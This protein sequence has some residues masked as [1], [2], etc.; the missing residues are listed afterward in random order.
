MEMR[1]CTDTQTVVG[2]IENIGSL[3]RHRTFHY[4]VMGVKTRHR[5]ENIH[6]VESRRN[7]NIYGVRSHGNIQCVCK[8]VQ[9]TG[10]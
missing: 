3:E 5:N 10:S 9:C 7:K 4:S 8:H 6:G 2:T 1:I